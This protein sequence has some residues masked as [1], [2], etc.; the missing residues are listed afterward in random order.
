M[1][2]SSGDVIS[3]RNLNVF[4]THPTPYGLG[5]ISACCAFGFS[6]DDCTDEFV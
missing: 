5:I 4:I 2:S 1:F 3:T 6:D